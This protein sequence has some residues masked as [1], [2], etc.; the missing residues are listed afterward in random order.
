M[1]PSSEPTDPIT[2]RVT[3]AMAAWNQ[4][5][6]DIDRE[7]ENFEHVRRQTRDVF[8][9]V[10]EALNEV[11]T[12][13][14]DKDEAAAAQLFNAVVRDLYVF[15]PVADDAASQQ[16]HHHNRFDLA[17]LLCDG[18]A[19]MFDGQP[20]RR[21]PAAAAVEASEE[22]IPFQTFLKNAV[23][24]QALSPAALAKRLATID[25]WYAKWTAQRLKIAVVAKTRDLCLYVWEG[26][27]AT[28]ALSTA[29]DG[30]EV[31]A[32]QGKEF[33]AATIKNG[34]AITKLPQRIEVGT[35]AVQIRDAAGKGWNDLFARVTA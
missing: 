8:F 24:G 4:L 6:A 20:R 27:Q 30:R 5:L 7:E 13:G 21:Q 34:S 2:Q 18:V 28:L 15:E 9:S 23:T 29:L 10:L 17:D 3:N 35:F 22:F 32:G 12:H 26:D 31:R 11:E 1:T 33:S 14:D 19:K 16:R 25:W